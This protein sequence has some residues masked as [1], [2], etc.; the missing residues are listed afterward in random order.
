[1]GAGAAARASVAGPGGSS[2]VA[3]DERAASCV[4]YAATSTEDRRGSIPVQL[5][6]CRATIAT[7]PHRTVAGE[8]AADLAE[9]RGAAELWVQPLRPPRPRRRTP[10]APYR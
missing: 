8:H 1:M 2:V 5:A 3:V 7:L 6:E 10:G 4:I 9:L